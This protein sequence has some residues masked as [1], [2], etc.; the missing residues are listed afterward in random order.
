[1]YANTTQRVKHVQ[2]GVGS[3][4]SVGEGIIFVVCIGVCSETGSSPFWV[5]L[6]TRHDPAV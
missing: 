3:L 4:H 1:M 6:L 2:A 5:G